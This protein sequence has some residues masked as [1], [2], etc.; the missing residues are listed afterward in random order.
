MGS[1]TATG[2]RL[3]SPAIKVFERKAMNSSQSEETTIKDNPSQS[4]AT[5]PKP[6]PPVPNPTQRPAALHKPGL[7]QQPS[8]PANPTDRNKKPW[9]S[10]TTLPPG[11]QQRATSLAS[12]TAPA[13][14]PTSK[15]ETTS[16]R[17]EQKLGGKQ[18]TTSTPKSEPQSEKPAFKVKAND[19]IFTG[20]DSVTLIQRLV[21]VDGRPLGTQR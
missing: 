5:E 3:E 14:I 13:C 10:K 9:L 1:A 7:Q 17:P 12:I 15:A 4:P 16:K 6:L 19:Q 2:F 20:R 8:S 11:Q 18:P 21:R